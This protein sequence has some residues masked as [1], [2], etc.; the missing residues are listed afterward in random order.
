M[1]RTSIIFILFF[2]GLFTSFA[3]TSEGTTAIDYQSLENRLAKSDK[4]LADEKKA[5]LLKTWV[6]RAKVLEEIADVHAKI[7][8]IN[9]MKN[10]EI[11]IYMKEPKEAKA[12]SDGRE[13]YIYDRV[14]F[15]F[16]GGVLK[17]WEET[18][19]ILATAKE[20]AVK[21]YDKVIELDIDKKYEKKVAEGLKNIRSI[22]GKLALANYY[23]KDY[24]KSHRAFAAYSD[25]G[26]RKE[27]NITDTAFTFY[28]GVTAHLAKMYK[29]AIV[30]FEKV[31]NLKYNDPVIYST[32]KYCYYATGDT[33][34]G[35][36]A[37]NRGLALYPDNVEVIVELINV[38][39][40]KGESTKALE[41]LQKAKEKDPTNKSFYFA[42]GT[43]YDKMGNTAKAI[44][45]YKK[46]CELDSSYFDAFYNLGV[47]YFNSGVKMTEAA[48]NEPDDKKYVEKKKLADEEFKKVLP[49]MEK[50]Y[51]IISNTKMTDNPDAN[52]AIMENKKA[53]LETLKTLY[54]RLKMNSQFDKVTKLLQ[55]L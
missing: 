8:R 25:L 28:A 40:N 38:Y 7:L 36:D 44:E 12:Y 17:N 48:N 15:I 23:K 9:S 42:E 26:E 55:E 19:P 53:T 43:L 14:T 52:N 49:Y 27:V 11:K 22:Y 46:A 32:L 21:A 35:I 6:D 24:E 2:A 37:L 34:K 39:L 16:E 13:E 10:S 20:D 30:Y 47:I 51:Y 4:N 31:A 1:K 5:N 45:T 41:F 29:E 33:A 50:A 54:Y 18:K 3:Q